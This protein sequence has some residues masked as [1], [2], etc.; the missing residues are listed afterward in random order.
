MGRDKKISRRDKT[1]Q[2]QSLDTR[3]KTNQDSKSLFETRQDFQVLRNLNSR[4]DETLAI[5]KKLRQDG[6][7]QRFPSRFDPPLTNALKVDLSLNPLFNQLQ[8]HPLKNQL[9]R[10]TQFNSEVI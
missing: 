3:F 5:F 7:R 8:H 4:Q 9:K 6:T 10:K 2:G 1:R